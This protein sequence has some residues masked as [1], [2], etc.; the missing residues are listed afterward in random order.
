[1]LPYRS[2]LI[3]ISRRKERNSKFPS[4]VMIRI[5]LLSLKMCRRFQTELCRIE[6]NTVSCLA[7]R[8]ITG[9]IYAKSPP[10]TVG[11]PP[12]SRWSPILQTSFKVLLTASKQ[13][14][15]CIG[16]SS[17]II[18]DVLRIKSD[19]NELHVILHTAFI[20]F[21]RGILNPE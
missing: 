10:R 12:N 6:A 9:K 15:C 13:A 3:T 14:L 18:R 2:G 19:R 16:T 5:L 4:L 17:Q 21:V 8:R 7:P 11:I 1:M 20:S